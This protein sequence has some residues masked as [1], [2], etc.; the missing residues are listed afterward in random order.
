[1]AGGWDRMGRAGRLG[2]GLSGRVLCFGPPVARGGMRLRRPAVKRVFEV[3]LG[4]GIRL[5]AATLV[6]PVLFAAGVA[7]A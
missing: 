3:R 2:L 7:N 1:M 5:V 6:W 4:L